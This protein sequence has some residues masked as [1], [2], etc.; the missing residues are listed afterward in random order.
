MGGRD[1]NTRI[2]AGVFRRTYPSGKASIRIYFTFRGVRC[3]ETLRHLDPDVKNHVK[4]AQNL[5]A[6]IQ[7]EIDRGTFNYLE[8]F[9]NSKRARIF[10]FVVSKRTVR[11]IGESW[12]ADIERSLPH[13]TYR[14]YRGPMER[15]VYPAIGD[16]Q[17]RDVSVEHLRRMFRQADICLKTARNYSIPLKAVF[18]RAIDDDDIDRNPMDR[19]NIK[20][21]IPKDRHRTNYAPDP[22][23]PAEVDALLQA[24]A[25]ITP[26]WLNYFQFAFFTGM[27]PSELYGLRW[28][29]VDLKAAT[30]HVCRA[31]VERQEKGTK[32]A[33]STRDVQLC[34]MALQ[35]LRR[36]RAVTGLAGKEVFTNPRTGDPLVD[37]QVTERR[38]EASRKHAKLRR[39]NQYQSRHT[40]ASNMLS[41]GANPLFVAKQLGHRDLQMLFKVYA[42]WIQ[43]DS[44]DNPTYGQGGAK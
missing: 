6:T 42:K 30:A 22:F 35:A 14:S 20:S 43:T 27:R 23:E 36:Q 33:A 9:P 24:C 21:L 12:L 4:V 2:S 26:G 1:L 7:H 34:P 11:E 37:Y 40:Y 44:V 3:P 25:E 16:M 38:F 17:I 15:F 32:T 41:Q 10:G 8:H 31:I 13:S 39:R 19:I 18:E 29:D 28:P 5:R